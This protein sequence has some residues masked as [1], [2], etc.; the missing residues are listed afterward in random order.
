MVLRQKSFHALIPLIF[1]AGCGTFDDPKD[2]QP[3]TSSSDT[4]RVCLYR[5]APRST[6][7]VWLDWYLDGRWRGQITP[8]RYYC[9]DTHVGRHIV[10]VEDR[11]EKVEFTLEKDQQVFIRFEVPPVPPL[12]GRGR[13]IYPVLVDRQTA[14]E[15]FKSK[16][17]D[18]DRP[19]TAP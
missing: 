7:G 2:Y 17:Y 12:F 4:G 16:G 1:L 13:D 3:S 14:Q 9:M 10:R 5:T 6:P 19:G 11:N 18:L 15:E 8:Y